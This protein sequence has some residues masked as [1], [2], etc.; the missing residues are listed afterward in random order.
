MR[1]IACLP[2]AL[3]QL[4]RNGIAFSLSCPRR[5]ISTGTT[6]RRYQRSRRCC[7]SAIVRD[8]DETFI[9]IILP[10]L[11]VEILF[12]IVSFKQHAEIRVRAIRVGAGCWIGCSESMKNLEVTVR[13]DAVNDTIGIHP[14]VRSR[15]VHG[16]IAPKRQPGE[17][18]RTVRIIT[19]GVQAAEVVHNLNHAGFRE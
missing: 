7:R 3:T 11:P 10:V 13:P 17:R 12:S 4:L 16:P 8:T 1:R 5:P 9:L 15:R 6:C 19:G 18:I 2:R 14:P